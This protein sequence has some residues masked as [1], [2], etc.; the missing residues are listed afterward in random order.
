[1]SIGWM[2]FV[3]ALIALEK[4]IPWRRVAIW[5][6][7]GVLVVLGAMVLRS[8]DALPGFTVPGDV[9]MSGGKSM[10]GGGMSTTM[11]PK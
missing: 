6:T 8:P 5:G 2:A 7:A 9:E 3:A 11:N 10:D 4:T 1:M